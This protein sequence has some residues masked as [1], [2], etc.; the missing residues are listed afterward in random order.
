[1]DIGS[2]TFELVAEH[3]NALDYD[4]PLG[5]SCDN[6]K[7]FATFRLY[8]DSNEKSYFLVRGVDGPSRV[9]DAENVKQ[10]I[11]DAR[12]DKATKVGLPKAFQSKISNYQ[13]ELATAGTCSVLD[14]PSTESQPHYHSCP[15]HS[16]LDGCPS[17]LR[18]T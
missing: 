1:M 7:L 14:N 4:G 2:R 3:L 12:A 11:K 15:A 10:A 5:L 17:T 16:E 9:A 8:W 6:T 18:S 13:F